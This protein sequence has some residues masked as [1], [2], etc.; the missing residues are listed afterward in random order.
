MA[1]ALKT[2][3]QRTVQSWQRYGLA[4]VRMDPLG[5]EPFRRPLPIFEM[6]DPSHLEQFALGC[7][8]DM[9]GYST[10]Q[11]AIQQSPTDP[12]PHGVF[13]GTLRSELSEQAIKTGILKSGGYAGF[14]TRVR[15]MLIGEDN[16]NAEQHQF[17]RLRVKNSGDGMKYSVNIQTEGP[18]STDIFQHR[19]WLGTPGEWEDVIIP[20]ADFALTNKG[21]ILDNQ[22]EMPRESIRTVGISVLEKPGPYELG[23]LKV[24]CVSEIGLKLEEQQQ[25]Q[26]SGQSS[27]S[28]PG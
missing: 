18:A 2:R 10:I 20:L 27:Q 23:I 8:A 21:Q 12:F 6:S 25:Q 28:V 17:L 19:L 11:L 4:V 15:E 9:G 14:R 13:R 1:S 22:F 26:E 16:W 24:D 3:L 7:D 5:G